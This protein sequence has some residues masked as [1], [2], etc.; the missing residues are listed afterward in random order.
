MKKIL[1]ATTALVATASVAAAEVTLSG[2]G[3]FGLNYVEGRTI[4]AGGVVKDDETR[5]EQRFRLDIRGTTESDAGVEFTGRIR[6]ETNEGGGSAIATSTGAA[7][8]TVE[9]G[10][11]RLDIGNTS[12][13]L[14]SGD[15]VPWFSS[16]GLTDALF[17]AGQFA[18]FGH[19]GGFGSGS[20]SAPTIKVRYTAGD[21]TVGASYSNNKV[22]GAADL[23]EWQIGAAYDFGVAKVGFVY[24]NE[25][26]VTDDFWAVGASGDIGQL[27]YNITIA[28]TDAQDVAVGASIYY[29]VSSATTIQFHVAEGGGTAPADEVAFG[30]GV[31]HSLGGGVSLRGHVGQNTSGTTVADL[32]V[33]FNF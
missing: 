23:T 17:Y 11:F 8:M 29:D 21:F 12:D 33:R 30:I 7:E 13:L 1:I 15:V 20:P 9:S 32:G 24:G 6:L 3:R 5:V 4:T 27:S 25:D 16:I 10:G 28:D 19:I 31:N 18:D 22:A 26:G 14:D 2:Y